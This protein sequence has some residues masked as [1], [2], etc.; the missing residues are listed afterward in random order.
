MN[1]NV[2]IILNS[3][4]KGYFLCDKT[5]QPITTFINKE[6]RSFQ[7]PN[8]PHIGL[9]WHLDSEDVLLKGRNYGYMGIQLPEVLVEFV[10]LSFVKTSGQCTLH[11][12]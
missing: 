4:L 10:D 9:L 12:M 2:L 8:V 5:F 6:N 1:E 7:F 3:I 11:V